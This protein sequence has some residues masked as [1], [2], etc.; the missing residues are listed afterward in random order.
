MKKRECFKTAKS[1]KLTKK[2]DSLNRKNTNALHAIYRI[3][4]DFSFIDSKKQR[5]E[6]DMSKI[7][8]RCDPFTPLFIFHFFTI[9]MQKNHMRNSLFEIFL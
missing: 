5:Q 8:L 7:S 3:C 9:F 4:N 6:S 2:A 1:S